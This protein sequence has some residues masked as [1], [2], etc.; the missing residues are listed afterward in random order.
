MLIFQGVIEAARI[1]MSSFFF[2]GWLFFLGI[3]EVD[4][5]LIKALFPGGG[6]VGEG[7]P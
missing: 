1:F 6:G 2:K 7:G 3:M 5:H 4:N